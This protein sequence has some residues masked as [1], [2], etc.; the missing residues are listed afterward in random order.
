M[1]PGRIDRIVYISPPDSDARK[2]IFSIQLRRIPHKPEVIDLAELAKLSDG[3]TGAEITSVCREACL[4]AMKEGTTSH[5]STCH[6]IF[7]FIPP[8]LK[9]CRPSSLSCATSR[10][11]LP[12]SLPEQLQLKCFN[13]SATFK[14]SPN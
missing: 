10:M 2:A 12:S 8:F 14:P 9:T 11:Q 7:S 4:A 1:R 13:S 6:Q 3:L 5:F